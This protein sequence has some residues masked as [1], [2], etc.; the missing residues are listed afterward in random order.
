MAIV[1]GALEIDHRKDLI[2][3]LRSSISTGM[4]RRHL[5][6]LELGLGCRVEESSFSDEDYE[7]EEDKEHNWK[8]MISRRGKEGLSCGLGMDS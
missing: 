5:K 4:A 7:G 8:M 2:T 3:H 6:R 1:I